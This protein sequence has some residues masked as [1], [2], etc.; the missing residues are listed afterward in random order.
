MMTELGLGLNASTTSTVQKNCSEL[1]CSP[2]SP[3]GGAQASLCVTFGLS[4][5][6][7]FSFYIIVQF[8]CRKKEKIKTNGQ[9]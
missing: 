7:Y 1:R 9:F 5:E 3:G 8:L 4:V 2:V 6:Q